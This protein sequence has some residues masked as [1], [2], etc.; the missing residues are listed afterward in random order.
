MWEGWRDGLYTYIS[1]QQRSQMEVLGSIQA[2]L[3]ER[4]LFVLHGEQLT[5]RDIQACID[6]V[7]IGFTKKPELFILLVELFS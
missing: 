2:F 4:P 1:T 5:I 6:G 3:F 7:C